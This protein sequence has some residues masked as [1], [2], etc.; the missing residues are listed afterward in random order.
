MVTIPLV[1]VL[2]VSILVKLGLF[3]INH[4]LGK[5]IGS[6]TLLATAADSRNDVVATF[7]VLT[8]A[9]IEVTTGLPADGY[10]GLGV[11]IFILY[12]GAALAKQT[13]SPLL[14]EAADPAL[15]Q[16]ILDTVRTNPRVL[17]YHDLMV[18]DYGPGQRF[19][20]I[21]VEMDR[22]E[23]PLLCHDIIDDLERECLTKHNVHL[24]VHYDPVVTGD[25]E[26][27]RMRQCVSQILSA[28]DARL[29]IHDFRMVQ[30][31]GH[32]NLIFD[33]AI[34]DDLLPKKKT[35]KTYLDTQ[36]CDQGDTTYYTVITFDPTAFNKE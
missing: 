26:L 14:G 13:I 19:A 29:S 25:A 6:T 5:R 1:V 15:Q 36:L 16:I 31:N 17:G 33:I 3:L 11:A 9:V 30:G 21:H 18:H 2:S 35:I 23:D 10:I 8:A 22:N 12:S 34:P 32:T 27:D 24:V 7:A 4:R 20:S 28:Y